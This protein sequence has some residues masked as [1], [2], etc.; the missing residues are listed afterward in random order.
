MS[1]AVVRGRW[2]TGGG[3]K[4]GG[5]GAGVNAPGWE[6]LTAWLANC[7]RDPPSDAHHVRN[8]DEAKTNTYM[9]CV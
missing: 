5:V 8:S 9:D 6:L 7:E 2:C 1:G 4:G 3:G